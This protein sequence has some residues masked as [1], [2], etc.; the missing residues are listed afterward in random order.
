VSLAMASERAAYKCAGAIIRVTNFP[1]R[2]QETPS[3]RG[4]AACMDELLTCLASLL[5]PAP[6]A[7]AP[8]LEPRQPAG[9]CQGCR[10][11]A[12]LLG[13]NQS[14]SALPLRPSH[15]CRFVV[16]CECMV[17]A[18]APGGPMALVGQPPFCRPLC[19][20]AWRNPFTLVPCFLPGRVA[21]TKRA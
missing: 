14:C 20:T 4:K 11:A 1:N 2:R 17:S 8:W 16:C 9:P 13:Q 19:D 7:A 21:R 10:N 12:L 18:N 15:T 6:G 3:G 5:P